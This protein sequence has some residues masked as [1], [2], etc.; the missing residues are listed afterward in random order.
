MSNNHKKDCAIN[1]IIGATQCY[2]KG[3][4][5]KEAYEKSIESYIYLY[6]LAAEK[7]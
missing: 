7:K 3:D 2:I 4:L 1:A 6:N 5:S